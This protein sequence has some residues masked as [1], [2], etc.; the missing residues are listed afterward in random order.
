MSGSTWH[1]LTRALQV[2]IA[3]TFLYGLTPTS[4]IAQ[5]ALDPILEEERRRN[6]EQRTN[7]LGTL[8]RRGGAPDPGPPQEALGPCFQIDRLT[9]EG[10][11]LLSPMELAAITAKYVPKCMQGADIQAVMRELDATYADRGYITTKTYIP[12]QN[13]QQGTLILSVLEGR[14]E[15]ILLIDD[16][17]QIESKRGERQL[18]TAFPKSRGELFQL[19][20]FEQGLDQMNRLASVEAVLKLQP[21]AEPGGSYVIVQRVQ[22]DPVRGYLRL[23]NQ[24]SKSTGRNRLSFDLEVDDLIGANDTWTL[25]YVGS[26]NTNA[27]SLVG[28][29]PYGYWTFRGD[30]SYSEYLTP[31]NTL[32]ELFGTSYSAGLNANYVLNRDQS[33]KT[34]LS[35]GLQVRKS[36]RFIN[37]ARLTPQDLTTLN[38]GIKH[39]QLGERARHSFDATLTLGTS[40]FGA[41]SDSGDLGRDIP[42]AQF[43]KVGAG[44]QR[45]GALGELGT[46]VT[47]VRLQFSPHT[48]YGS[49]QMVLGSYS[50]VRG[51]NAAVASGDSGTYVRN[52][53][54]LTPDVW[55]FLPTAL[56]ENLA[57]NAQFHL[58]LDAGV[59]RDRARETTEKAAGFGLGLSYYHKR[60]TLSGIFGAPLMENNS[61]DIGDPVAQ[62]RIDLKSF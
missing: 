48:L 2:G 34:E 12:A 27:L 58:F 59:T 54:Y 29:V 37:D 16:E 50:T 5:A 47:D 35:F 32:S 17:K 10:V 57:Q 39:L 15:D 26:E 25:G 40:L 52:D 28:S 38:F 11:T 3:C 55:N 36:D 42:R 19:R 51:Y 43:I 9:V 41:D 30:L 8:E 44:W 31:L 21:G 13:L 4:V 23:D 53:L 14:V 46:L 56:G 60:F 7:E 62:I 20:D 6:L 45:Q 1:K 18:S 33:S 61:F 22:N 24:G 49:E